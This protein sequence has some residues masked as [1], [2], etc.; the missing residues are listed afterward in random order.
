MKLL[1]TAVL[2]HASLTYAQVSRYCLSS[3]KDV[4]YSVNIPSNTASSGSGDIYFQITAPSSY[5]W[6]GFGEGAQ[7]KGSNIFIIYS[8]ADNGNVTLSPRLGVGEVMPLYNSAAQ[9]ALIDGSGIVNGVMTANVRCS[10]CESWSGGTLQV[11]S[12][13]ANF[14]WAYKGGNEIS[15]NSQSVNL[16]QHD[17]MGNFQLDL[18]VG[19]GGNSLN[20]FADSSNATASNSTGTTTGGD[21]GGGSSSGGNMGGSSSADASKASRH[22]KV[23]AHGILMSLAFLIFFP[24]GALTIRTL[25]SPNTIWVH[26]GAQTL[27]FAI[28]IAGVGLGIWIAINPHSEPSQ[29]SEAHPIIGLTVFSLLF[30]QPV[31]ALVHHAIYKKTQKRTLWAHAHVWLGRGLLI[32]GAINGGLGLQLSANTTKGEVAYGVIAGVVFVG[33]LV[34]LGIWY[35][36]KRGQNGKR[37]GNAAKREDEKMDGSAVALND[38]GP[39]R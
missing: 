11:T 37:G 39:N 19:T 3:A 8:D 26:A 17:D 33:Y 16:V 14:I 22:K 18:T 25:S 34:V 31:L 6:I 30:F 7:M 1:S 27:A 36:M 9:V 2:L 23:V 13:T 15:S 24:L 5:Q 10:N 29:I 20:P 21:G 4:C 32:L 28:A 38:M 35:G 12:T